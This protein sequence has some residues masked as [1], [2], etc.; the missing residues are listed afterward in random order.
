MSPDKSSSL[1]NTCIFPPQSINLITATSNSGK[2]FFIT[3]ILNHPHLFFLPNY[4]ERLF[5]INANPRAFNEPPLVNNLELLSLDDLDNVDFFESGTC[6]VIDD[7]LF[8]TPQL[9][10]FLKYTVHHK[11]L[12]CFLIT[13]NLIGDKLYG[14]TYLVHNI[15]LILKA[16]SAVR[17]ALELLHRFYISNDT[18]SYLRGIIS[19]AE[20]DKSIICLKLNAVAS[21]QGPGSTI[22][23]Y[24]RLEHLVKDLYCLAFPELGFM[25]EFQ[26]LNFDPTSVDDNQL[27][28]VP[29]KYVIKMNE[30]K[31][32]VCA[33][34]EIWKSMVSSLNDDIEH[35]FIY[36]MLR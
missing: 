2:T 9:I 7:L 36:N 31:A 26:S 11:N 29:A 13:Q 23:C 30:N 6:I 18:K 28:L 35:N 3:Q 10:H 20:R 34:E 19:K 17:L 15:I 24:S 33:K 16:N 22:I 1:V 21:Y 5:Y 8:T 25:E 32:T 4:I 27:I 14:L 12:T